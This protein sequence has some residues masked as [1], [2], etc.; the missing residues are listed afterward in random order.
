M[1]SLRLL[2]KNFFKLENILLVG[3]VL[4]VLATVLG[5]VIGIPLSQTKRDF[6]KEANEILER[7]VLID[8]HNDFPHRVR[9]N[10][11]N[12][13]GEF[14]FTEMQQYIGR[15]NGS[16]KVIHTDLERLK[17]GKLGAQFWVAYAKCDA[18]AKDAARI[19]LEQIDVI[20]RLVSKYPDH[21]EFVTD[22]V[23]IRTAFASKKTASLIGVES[24]HAIDSS[25]ALL[26]VFYHLGARYM[27]LT[28][29]CDVPWYIEYHI[30]F[31]IF[32]ES[33][34]LLVVT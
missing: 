3:V 23:G 15:L 25:L 18:L 30:G 4:V 29:N 17:K 16:G 31:V 27:T 7:H 28:H 33:N 13:F 2:F 22:S 20:K 6:E 5:L 9:V 12:K 34:N 26:R 8:G 11:Q 21:L 32:L 14:N 1:I 19:H 10:F 24:G